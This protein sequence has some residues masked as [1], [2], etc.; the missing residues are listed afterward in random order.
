ME[1]ASGLYSLQT[2]GKINSV[3]VSKI[4]GVEGSSIFRRCGRRVFLLKD[5][6]PTNPRTEFQQQGR[7]MFKY[8]VACWQALPDASKELWRVEQDERRR[9]PV[10]SGYNLYLSKFLLHGGPP[11]NP[12]G[13]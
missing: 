12:P 3:A 2:F 8:A 1:I 13:G 11:P 4:Y 7:S 5:Y 6:V 10:M 9:F